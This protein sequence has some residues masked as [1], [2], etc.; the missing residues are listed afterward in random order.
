MSTVASRLACLSRLSVLAVAFIAMQPQCIST[1]AMAQLKAGTEEADLRPK[2]RKGQET[3][4]DM[5]LDIVSEQNLNSGGKSDDPTKDDSTKQTVKQ[6]MG[7]LLRVKEVASSGAATV[8]LVYESLKFESD[9]AFG[10]VEFDSTTPKN[11]KDD[12]D[13]LLRPLV[14]LTLTLQFDDKGV[15]TNVTSSG[16][17]GIAG[18][19]LQQFTSADLV[20]GMFGPIMTIKSGSGKAKVGEKWTN[21]SSMA[22]PMGTTRIKTNYTL[23]SYA[24]PVARMN[25]Q[26]SVSIDGSSTGMANVREGSIT[27]KATWNTERGMLEDMNMTQRLLV[28]SHSTGE[29]G[30]TTRNTMTMSVTRKN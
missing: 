10:K 2:W 7:L 30:G 22:G 21:E 20:K 14:G 27:G 19:M 18:G 11:D 3:R 13:G 4:F 9:S 6:K 24:S 23:E 15:I 1:P 29:A 16:G 12:F 17:A 25:I 26:G 28:D 5:S 8:D